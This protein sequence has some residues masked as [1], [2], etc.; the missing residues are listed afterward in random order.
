[1]HPTQKSRMRVLCLLFR[2]FIFLSLGFSHVAMSLPSSYKNNQI[3]V[4][5]FNAR[6]TLIFI[7]V[8]TGDMSGDMKSQTYSENH[9]YQLSSASPP[10]RLIFLIANTLDL[11]SLISLNNPNSP[12]NSIAKVR[13]SAWM[14]CTRLF[15]PI[16]TVI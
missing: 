6:T 8:L 9:F 4:F 15:L 10:S 12:L 14:L 2:T 16:P 1:M 5:T 11:G 7:I 3:N 13:S